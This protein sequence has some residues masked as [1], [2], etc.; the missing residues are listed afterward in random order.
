MPQPLPYHGNRYII[1]QKNNGLYWEKLQLQEDLYLKS[2]LN[3]K[4][5]NSYL[6][7]VSLFTL[8]LQFFTVLFLA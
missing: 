4:V 5:D 2:I 8:W 1:Q 3:E 6:K 7:Q